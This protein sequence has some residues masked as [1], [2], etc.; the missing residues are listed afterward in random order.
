MRQIKPN[1]HSTAGYDGQFYSQIAIHPSLRAPGLRESLDA[2]AY[3]AMRPFLPWLSYLAGFGRPFWIVQAYA[4][5]N[6][7][8]WYLLAFGLLHYLRPTSRRDYLCI[9]AACLSSGCVFSATRTR[10]PSCSYTL[11]LWSVAR[12]RLCCGRDCRGSPYQRN[13]CITTD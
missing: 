7:L 3:R 8:F 4:L 10:G 2:P 13:L 5:S 9:L 6:L 11:F 1:V 12:R